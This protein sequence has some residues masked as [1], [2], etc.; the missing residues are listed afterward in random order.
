MAEAEG[1][2]EQAETGDKRSAL[3]DVEGLQHKK[4]KTS[5]LP[6]SPEQHKSIDGLLVAFKKRGRFDEIRKRVWAEFSESVRHFADCSQD[7]SGP[8]Q[9]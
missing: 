8:P 7:N 1:I 9:C 6:L 5:E 3:L 4:F 2:K